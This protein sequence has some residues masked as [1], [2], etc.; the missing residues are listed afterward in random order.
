MKTVIISPGWNQSSKG[1]RYDFVSDAYI[2]NGYKVIR[3]DPQSGDSTVI[4]WANGLKEIIDTT[5]GEVALWGFSIGSMA[6]LIVSSER[7]VSSLL[8]CS[9]SG[10]FKEYLPLID[11]KYLKNWNHSQMDAFESLSFIQTVEKLQSKESYV[12]AGEL[13]LEEWPSFR[14]VVDDLR[15]TDKFSVKV[16]DETHHDFSAPHY[17]QA[18]CDAINNL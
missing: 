7:P 4:D 1:A 12:F 15:N 14:K 5:E 18:I 8:L 17:R 2:A 9:P 11:D 10:F 3:Y 13:E 16:I 6:S